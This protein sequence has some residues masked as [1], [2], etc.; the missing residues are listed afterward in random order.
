MKFSWKNLAR[1]CSGCNQ[2]DWRWFQRFFS[3][4]FF[5]NSFARVSPVFAVSLLA[6]CSVGFATNAVASN[7]SADPTAAVKRQSASSQFVRAQDQRTIL[8]NKAPERRTLEDYKQVVNTYRRVYLITPHAA[9]VPDALLAVAELYTEMGERFGRSY[10]QSAVDTYQFLIREYPTSRYCQDAYLRSGKLQKD[11]LGDLA[12]ATKTFDAFLK[13]FPR[14]PHKREAQEARAELALLQNSAPAETA[15]RSAIARSASSEVERENTSTRSASRNS[16]QDS[17]REPP[18]V[19]LAEEDKQIASVN[20]AE[21]AVVP[22]VASGRAQQIR[23]ISAKAWQ[24]STR[25]TIE[26]ESGVQ[27]VS[28]RIANPDRIYFDLHGAKLTPVL[29]HTK[30]KTDGTILSAVRVAQKQSGVVRV[31]L[32]VNGVADYSASLLNNPSRLVID[33]YASAQAMQTAKSNEHAQ[34]GAGKESVTAVE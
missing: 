1:A 16:E 25:V 12:G 8:N 26:L 31:V 2:H 34:D 10:F 24:N 9:E 32:D 20:A 23:K 15:P 7:T 4:L 14:S 29:A 11:Q 19:S 13:T 3:S 6:A 18:S 22:S 17:E 30:I 5:N 28:G 21:K 33:L 27:Y